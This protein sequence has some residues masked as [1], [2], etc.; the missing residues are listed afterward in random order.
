V[1]TV[2]V[3]ISCKITF[4]TGYSIASNQS[5]IENA[6]KDYLAELRA[7]WEMNEKNS[8]IVRISQIESRLIAVEGVLDVTDTTING[9]NENLILDFMNIAVFGGVTVV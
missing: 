1:P 6:I 3:N 4:D 7:G 5:L 9:A 8:T 2:D